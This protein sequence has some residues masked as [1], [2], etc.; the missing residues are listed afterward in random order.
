MTRLTTLFPLWALLGALLAWWLPGLFAPGKPLIVPLLSLVMLGMGLTLDWRQF[1]TVWSR[2]S[3]VVL[4]VSLQF[5]I[6]PLAAWAIAIGL[7]L[8]PEL[9]VGMVLLGASPG[10]TASNLIC[11][12]ARG[13]VALSI[14]LTSVS[15]LLAIL[16][17]PALTLAYA[18]Q[19][20]PVPA[21]AMLISMLKVVLAPVAIG[22]AINTWLG[23]RLTRAKAA[24]PVIS[25]LAIVIII[26]IV[27]ALNRDQIAQT[28]ALLML[29]VMLHNGF[30]LLG[31]YWLARWL[32]HDERTARTLAIEVGMQ[33]SG[34]AVALASQYFS[35]AAALPG[36]IFSVWHNL[37]GSLLAAAWA[38]RPIPGKNNRSAQSRD[39]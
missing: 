39:Q 26:A 1:A 12:L 30:G 16:A 11:Y 35:A 9:A 15:T 13:D 5:L 7:R 20:V 2:R 29:A 8:P 23:R 21:A 27:V 28:G 33:N 14:T 3:V 25:M 4:G 36:A 19:Q 22:V 17:T 34:L 37:S 10:G 38:H 18:G 31:G 32:T 6:M 24:F